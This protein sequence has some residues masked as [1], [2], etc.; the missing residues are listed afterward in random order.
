[1]KIDLMEL[2]GLFPAI[3][4][5]RLA[6]DSVDM[7]DSFVEYDPHQDMYTNFVLGEKDEFIISQDMEVNDC[8]KYLNGI[9]VHLKIKAP[10]IFH[11]Y[12]DKQ[13][14][15][16]ETD[17]T[18][19]NYKITLRDFVE[20]DHSSNAP[21]DNPSGVDVCALDAKDIRHLSFFNTKKSIDI[22]D[23]FDADKKLTRIR[24]LS[25]LQLKRLHTANVNDNHP[26]VKNFISFIERLPFADVFMNIGETV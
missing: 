22:Y 15:I 7:S 8:P 6:T 12:L 19:L 14:C 2:S 9:M 3:Y 20:G 23:T 4:A 11:D 24:V 13:F 10:R 25:Y 16:D 18:N 17:H 26:D 1:M 5:M 21:S